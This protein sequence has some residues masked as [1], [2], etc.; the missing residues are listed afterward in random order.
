MSNDCAI[1]MGVQARCWRQKEK[2]PTSNIQYP[3]S[4][5]RARELPGVSC[6]IF[7]VGC[8]FGF[9]I[10]VKLALTLTLSPE[11]LIVRGR[12]LP[13]SRAGRLAMA[14]HAANDSPSPE[15][16]GRGEGDRCL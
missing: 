16:E 15:G 2:H 12:K 4:N 6:W 8:S 14:Q 13:R 7:D 5:I 11:E 10:G 9:E 1:V 3:I